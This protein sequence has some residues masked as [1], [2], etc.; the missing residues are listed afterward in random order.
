MGYWDLVG[1]AMT[2]DDE[3]EARKKQAR[4]QRAVR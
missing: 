1:L 3:I 4:E 2:V